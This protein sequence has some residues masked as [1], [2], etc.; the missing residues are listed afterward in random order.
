MLT[1]TA[2][3]ADAERAA[4]TR[5]S[6]IL[7]KELWTKVVEYKASVQGVRCC[8]RW[9]VTAK[10]DSGFIYRKYEP[11]IRCN[12]SSRLSR[13][14]CFFVFTFYVSSIPVTGHYVPAKNFRVPLTSRQLKP[15]LP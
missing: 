1:G 6:F 4:M 15:I 11:T 8:L 13:M 2:R 3:V 10:G 14:M 5:E 9:Q 7:I 12:T